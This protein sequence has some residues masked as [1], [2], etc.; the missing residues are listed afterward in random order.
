LRSK[1]RQGNDCRSEKAEYR[2]RPEK[3]VHVGLLTVLLVIPLRS[4]T[5]DATGASIKSSREYNLY[6]NWA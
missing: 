4:G 2:Q 5:T 3:V 1:A 6:L